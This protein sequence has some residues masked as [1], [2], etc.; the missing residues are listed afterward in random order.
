VYGLSIGA[1]FNE[2]SFQVHRSRYFLMMNVNVKCKFIQ[3]D[4]A[5]P[6]MR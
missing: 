4:S 2:R 1:S 3:R 6:L 5:K